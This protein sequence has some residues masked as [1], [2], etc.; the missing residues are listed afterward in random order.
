MKVPAMFRLIWCKTCYENI[1]N[2][3]VSEWPARISRVSRVSIQQGP[4]FE[5]FLH[6]IGMQET[7]LYGSN[8]NPGLVN[9]GLSIR[10]VLPK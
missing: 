9:H 6:H 5:E 2:R 7:L 1:T 10:E 3:E 8:V 4:P